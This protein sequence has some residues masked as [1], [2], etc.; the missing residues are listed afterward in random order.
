MGILV[1]AD[2]GN[3]NHGQPKK[4]LRL[5]ESSL[6]GNDQAESSSLRNLTLAVAWSGL[7]PYGLNAIRALVARF[8]V[9]PIVLGTTPDMSYDAIGKVAGVPIHWIDPVNTS[10]NWI[11]FSTKIPDV[12]LV[13]GWAT[14]AFNE[15]GRQVRENGGSVIVMVDNR[16]R[17]D[18]RQRV[19]PVVF[20]TKYRN[21]FQAAIVPGKS[22]RRFV[23][24]LGLP[25]SAIHEGLYGGN[26]NIFVPGPPLADRPR[27]FLFV[28]RFEERKGIRELAEAWRAIQP[29]LPDW[30]L[31]AVGEGGLRPLLEGVRNVVLHPFKQLTD[32]AECYGQSRFLVLPS[33]EDHWGVVV[34]EATRC[35]CGLLLSENVGA[36]DDLANRVNSFLFPPGRPSD[37]ANAMLRAAQL[38]ESQLRGVYHESLALAY[39]FGP[40]A[41]AD[42]VHRAVAGLPRRG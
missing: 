8:G 39:R 3:S 36:R 19:A 41:F 24:Y 32:L 28:G 31:H 10:I 33:R 18:L 16:W 5:R 2:P 26:P 30:E 42:A 20:N 7:P 40:S 23:R 38:G 1:A 12:L 21:W 25:D 34:H 22:A 37:I 29:Q 15:L 6:R 9:E 14:P 17:G 4:S 11:Y 13:S 27:R 35:G